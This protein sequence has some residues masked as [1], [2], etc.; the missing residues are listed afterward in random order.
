MAM[1]VPTPVFSSFVNFNNTTYSDEYGYVMTFG[2]ATGSD[3]SLY[4][5][6]SNFDNV[7]QLLIKIVSADETLSE[8][9]NVVL[10]FRCGSA[11][12]ERVIPVTNVETWQEVSLP[13]P[14]NG[15]L[16]ISRNSGSQN[17]TLKDNSGVIDCY[18]SNVKA[19][20]FN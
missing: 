7:T 20:I 4:T 1:A 17:D 11:D 18:I 2:R 12:F 6:T 16:T 5:S 9:K 10:R 8:T 19:V 3:D 14:L 13:A 15:A